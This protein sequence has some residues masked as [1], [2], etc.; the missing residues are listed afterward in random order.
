MPRIDPVTP[1]GD[2]V[3]EAKA[4]LRID[5]DDEDA[6]IASFIATAIRQ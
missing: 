2:A 1:P 4:Y 5:N 3:D 6:L